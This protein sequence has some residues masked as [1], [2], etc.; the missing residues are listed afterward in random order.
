MDSHDDY[1]YPYYD[2]AIN[3]SNQWANLPT[4]LPSSNTYVSGYG[5]QNNITGAR[6]GTFNHPIAPNPFAPAPRRP[7]ELR[8]TAQ[9]N[10]VGDK[11]VPRRVSIDSFDDY[12]TIPSPPPPPQPEKAPERTTI[13][14]DRSA[15]SNLEVRNLAALKD[16]TAS[17][18]VQLTT[19][20]IIDDRAFR[21]HPEIRTSRHGNTRKSRLADYG[22]DYG[23][24]L[25]YARTQQRFGRLQLEDIT[26]R[27][28]KAREDGSPKEATDKTG[29]P[30]RRT[31]SKNGLIIKEHWVQEAEKTVTDNRLQSDI[32]MIQSKMSGMQKKLRQLEVQ[33]SRYAENQ[34]RILYRIDSTCYFDHPEWTQGHK[35]IVSRMPVKNLDLF[36][37]RNK[38]IL[39]IVY[40]DFEKTSGEQ[41]HYSKLPQPES[42][43]ESIHPVSRRLRKALDILLKH[44]WRYESMFL[45]LQQQGEIKAPY[46]FVYHHRVYWKDM[47]MQ[48]PDAVRKHLNLLAIY[49][50]DNYG[51]EYEAADAA[52]AQRRISV[53][54]VK[55]LFQPGDILIS[56]T[57]G[58]Y[59]GL[60]ANSWPEEV[61]SKPTSGRPAERPR[62]RRSYHDASHA[63]S[64]DSD[65]DDSDFDIDEIVHGPSDA[66]EV[67]KRDAMRW[68]FRR[69]PH[70]LRLKENDQ[71]KTASTE[72]PSKEFSVRVWKWS[73]DGD[74]KREADKVTVRLSHA[75]ENVSTEGKMWGMHELDLYPLK[76]APEMLVQ[77]LRKRGM[78]FWECRKR[79][80]IS[81]RE[82]S[83]ETQSEVSGTTLL[84]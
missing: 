21:Q 20:G 10:P 53:E 66:D 83:S 61:A 16:R 19:E 5:V 22:P 45:H 31:Q 80:L 33:K 73:F 17:R 15:G 26:R 38:N 52:F 23:S 79:R 58:Q 35:S 2:G 51:Q 32:E 14:D 6:A 11:L 71:E 81:Y 49:V 13:S 65:V 56:R 43:R 68:A 42:A 46:L 75:A 57:N 18:P 36:L 40:R 3:S 12:P 4:D 76:F 29:F 64:F 48:F 1:D 84:W 30:E 70:W 37:E 8:H 62:M 25:G 9:I 34:Y 69:I 41:K 82:T 72:E 47:L 63:Q 27:D 77:E 59:R 39:F 7:G 67:H 50:S 24:F 60:V 54:H 28:S 74:F 55:Y 44:D 78:M